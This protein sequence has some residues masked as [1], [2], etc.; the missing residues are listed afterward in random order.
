MKK[1]IILPI[2]VNRALKKLGKDIREARI[3]RQITIA[4][5]AERAN[6]TAVTISKV[7]KGDPSVSLGSFA[8][9]VFILGMIDKLR[10]LFDLFDNPV[11]RMLVEK[12]FPKRVRAMKSK[13]QSGES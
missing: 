7:E 4:M 10:D 2:P 12:N 5:M 8:T 3:L 9:V 6:V 13:I 1:K 11:S